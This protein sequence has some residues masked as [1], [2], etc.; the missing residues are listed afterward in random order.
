MKMNEYVLVTGASSKLGNLIS[1]ILAKKNYSLLLHYYKSEEKTISLAKNLK[2][3]FN[4]QNFYPLYLDL[5]KNHA[6][7]LISEKI[8]SETK[9]I[10]GIINNASLYTYDKFNNFN[11]NDFD[12]NFNIHFRN[13]IN[14]ISIISKNLSSKKK[15]GFAINITDENLNRD[16][17]FSYNFSKTLLSIWS[18]KNFEKTLKITEYKPGNLFPSKNSEKTK[19]DFNNKFSKLIKYNYGHIRR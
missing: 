5:S 17:H 6:I 14:L 16:N 13:P 1:K 10:H 15:E 7:E 19:I 12:S 9:T 8:F 18:N 2:E 11:S 4:N 3:K